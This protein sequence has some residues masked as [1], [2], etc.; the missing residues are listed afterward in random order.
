MNT[1]LKYHKITNK[2]LKIIK[3]MKKKQEQQNKI[4]EK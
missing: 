3:Q 4:Q 1:T 2:K